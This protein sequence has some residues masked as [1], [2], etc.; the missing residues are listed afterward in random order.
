MVILERLRE[1]VNVKVAEL[2]P[3][4]WILHRDNAPPHKAL[5]VKAVTGPKIG[6]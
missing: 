1:A 4:D 5:C 6:Y 3:N 2:W